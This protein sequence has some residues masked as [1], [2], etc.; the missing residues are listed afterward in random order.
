[1]TQK[2][3]A[4][5]HCNDLLFFFITVTMQYDRKYFCHYDNAVM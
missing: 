3:V 2:V 1:M 5:D 4:C